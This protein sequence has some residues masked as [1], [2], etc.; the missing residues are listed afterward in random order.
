MVI[1]VAVMVIIGG[2]ALLLIS[3]NSTSPVGTSVAQQL[4][5]MVT[6]P[7]SNSIA[8]YAQN[9]GFAG[10]DLITAIAIALAESSGNP[11]AYNPET[12]AGTPVGKGSYGLWQ[13]YLNAHPE[14]SG[15]NLY[16]PQTNANAAYSIYS[17]AG[18]SFS[19]WSTFNS[20]AYQAQLAVAQSQVQG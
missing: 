10:N 5:S 13:I 15:Q 19:A 3:M 18:E 14:F 7:T 2:V 1:P 8:N 17:G 11:N 4:T 20:G 9:A 6:N 12:A 16:D